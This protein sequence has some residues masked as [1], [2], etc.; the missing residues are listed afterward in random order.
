MKKCLGYA[1]VVVLFVS[2]GGACTANVSTDCTGHCQDVDNDCVKKCND[3]Q[4]KTQCDTDLHNCTVS[5][6]GGSSSG[7]SSG[8][9]T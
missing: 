7:S 9:H 5:C 3:D 4:C 1:S 6:G 2:L 8:S